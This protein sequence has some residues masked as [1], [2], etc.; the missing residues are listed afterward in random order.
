MATASIAEIYNAPLYLFWLCKVPVHKPLNFFVLEILWWFYELRND[1]RVFS[2]DLRQW[3]RVLDKVVDAF[4]Y[5]H[6]DTALM[7]VAMLAYLRMHKPLVY[8]LVTEASPR[9]LSMLVCLQPTF[10]LCAQVPVC[11]CACMPAG[12]G[13]FPLT[14]FHS[15]P[16]PH[17]ED[18]LHHLSPIP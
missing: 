13:T 3:M 6:M 2:F 1:P 16:T 8:D 12:V 17:A 5:T 15:P 11:Q 18:P 14:P 10:C 7:D 4:G 9:L